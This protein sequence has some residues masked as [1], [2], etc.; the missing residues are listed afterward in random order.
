MPAPCSVDEFQTDSGFL[1]LLPA[2]GGIE[3]GDSFGMLPL[4]QGHAVNE[5]RRWV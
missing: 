5:A 2:H 1:C 3:L 4:R